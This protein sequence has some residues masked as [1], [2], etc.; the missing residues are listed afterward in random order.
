M[1]LFI[2]IFFIIIFSFKVYAEIINK[3][4]IEGNNRISNSNI[5]L[6][7]KIELNEDYDNNKINR[8]LKNL[9][10]TEF[11]EKI[12]IGV[13]NNILIIKVLENPIVQSIEITGVK[14]KTVLEL[15]RD[16]LSLKEKNPFVENKVRRDEIKL[17]N[18]LKING[19]YF[20]EIKSKVKNNENNTI[21]LK[22]EIELGEKAYISSIKFIGDKKIKDRKLKNIIVS[23][24]SK[25]WK[26]IS[27][28]KFVDSNRI[29]LDEKLLKNYYKN[30]GYY[31]VKVYSS[32]AQL[33]DSNNFELV[34]N[35][36]AGEKF[37]F[38]NITLDVP[39][40]YSKDNFEEIFKTMDKLKGK[41]Y[42]I[43]RIDKI[44]K[45]IDKI[46]IQKQFEFINASYSEKLRAKNIDLNI[47][48]TES[49]KEYV[50]KINILGNYITNESVIRNEI[51]SDEGDPYN[52]I[53]FKKSIN[54]IK[55]RNIF[56]TVQ[57][58]VKD[59]STDQLKVIDVI[60][61]EKPTGEISA[62]AGTGT[63][64]SSISFSIAENNYLG[65][66]SKVNLSATLS[67][68]SVEGKFRISEPNFKNSDKT[69]NTTIESSRNDLMSKFGYKTNETGF[70]FGTTFEQYQ[71]IFFSPEISMYYESL[72]TS[73]KASN[74]K[75][76]QEGDYLDTNF[77]Y[78]LNLNK[79]NQNFQP[80][81]GYRSTFSQSLP[82]LAEDKSI[83]NAYE[84][85]NYTKLK[86]ETVFSFIF[87]AK[88]INN[89]DDDV[90][91]S[92]RIFIP[93]RK[94]RGFAAGKIGPKDSDD[95][96]GGNYGTA[97]NLAATLPNFMK[98]LE[99]IDFSLFLDTAN[100]WG[101]DY[102]SSLDSNKIRSSTGIAVDWFTPIGPLSF[103]LAS[104][105]TKSSTDET[106]TFRFRIGTT[107]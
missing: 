43:N 50:E 15:L 58:N 96:I 81:D 3:I 52:E 25:F 45:E 78:S 4:E 48:L 26:F 70:S 66:G 37:K 12:N 47:K 19:Y 99:N 56:K 53:L 63:S 64:G 57:T 106:E 32:F 68:D 72:T 51:I 59:G 84:Y 61:E 42:S 82:I 13:K 16:N 39:K 71:D 36:N 14:N 10:E 88:S 87:F 35:I 9:Y 102:N 41:S 40:G 33:I 105:I 85:A 101:V 77:S 17:K 65:R 79:L 62:G 86:N 54:K 38:N 55:S 6:F 1:R 23:E 2:Y 24:E 21:D 75:K 83:S 69:L 103:S 73:S 7:G 11:F 29:K 95:F 18:I 31:N 74:A 67:D 90:R 94:L 49:R 93:S 107:F 80:T 22:Y 76:K 44:L 5:I 34:F 104:P 20:S 46:V 100:V 97:M 92:K 89:F 8:T 30:N 27:K 91:I 60:V 98:D 28:K